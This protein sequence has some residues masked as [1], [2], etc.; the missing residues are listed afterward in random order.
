MAYQITGNFFLGDGFCID[1]NTSGLDRRQKCIQIICEK[2]N[3]CICRRLLDSFQ[4]SVLRLLRHFVGFRNNV[5]LMLT[6]VWLD[7][8]IIIE[9]LTNIIDTDARFFMSNVAD[10]RMIAG[11]C[12][13]TGLA[14]V[15]GIG[16]WMFF[17]LKRL[18]KGVCQHTASGT[19]FSVDNVGVRDISC[20]DCCLEMLL[21]LLLS[22]DIFKICHKCLLFI[23][24]R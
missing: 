14:S 4:K 18:C 12:L 5:Y 15:A 21:C 23:M 2:N 24:I 22:Y 3:D 1:R 6:A 7:L 10:I 8:D 17:T 16:V 20:L 11:L 13:M 19:G 9:L